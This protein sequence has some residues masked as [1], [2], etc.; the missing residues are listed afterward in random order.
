MDIDIWIYRMNQ[1]KILP[2]PLHFHLSLKQRLA[3]ASCF[4][5]SEIHKWE[6]HHSICKLFS[7]FWYEN[8]QSFRNPM[9]LHYQRKTVFWYAS[10]LL[11]RIDSNRRKKNLFLLHNSSFTLYYLI[12]FCVGISWRTGP[13]TAKKFILQLQ[14]SEC[15]NP[16]IP[17]TDTEN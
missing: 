13:E 12:S 6:I 9:A 15:D 2:R 4:Y 7:Y 5:H 1:N 16:H 17:I 8:D 3:W 10:Y 14:Q 11:M